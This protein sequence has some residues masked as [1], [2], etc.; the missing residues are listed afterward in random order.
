MIL[1]AIKEFFDKGLRQHLFDKY[2]TIGN[3]M[4]EQNG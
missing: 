1:N 2:E 4:G 3:I